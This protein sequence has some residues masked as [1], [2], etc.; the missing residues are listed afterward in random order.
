MTPAPMM[1]SFL[2]VSL[3]AR[4]P[5]ESTILS[6]STFAGGI[7]DGSEP[8]AMMMCLPEAVIVSSSSVDEGETSTR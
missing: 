5:V 2:G 7:F 6:L 8:V 4:A 3:N 1:H